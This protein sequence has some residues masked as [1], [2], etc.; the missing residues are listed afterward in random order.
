VT[1]GAEFARQERMVAFEAIKGKV[2]SGATF[3]RVHGLVKRS[4]AEHL[5]EAHAKREIT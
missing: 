1:R 2:Q 5:A 3:C 4:W